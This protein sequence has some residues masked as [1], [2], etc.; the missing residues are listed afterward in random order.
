MPSPSDAQKEELV[1]KIASLLAKE[2][3]IVESYCTIP[4]K[5]IYNQPIGVRWEPLVELYE[6]SDQNHI[7]KKD[8]KKDA[9]RLLSEMYVA[10]LSSKEISSLSWKEHQKK[11]KQGTSAAWRTHHEQ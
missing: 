6:D 3:E 4:Q 2:F 8:A 10:T 9:Y 11:L 1:A 7:Q 5:I